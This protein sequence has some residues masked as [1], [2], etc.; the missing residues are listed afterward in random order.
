M[1]N[2]LPAGADTAP[3]LTDVLRSALESAC[4]EP[5]RLALPPVQHA[6][7][8]L[9]D[10]LGVTNL[11]AYAGHARFLAGRMQ[12]RDVIRTVTPSTTAVALSSLLTGSDPGEHGVTGYR[13]RDP[14]SGRLVNQLSEIG[15]LGDDWV[16]RPGLFE[17]ATERGVAVHVVSAPQYQDSGLTRA[18]FAG[19]A[20]HGVAL[21]AS[22]FDETAAILAGAAPTVTYLYAPELDQIGH[23]SGVASARWLAELEALD[24][25]LE[26]FAA[27][28]PV[29]VGIL[30][31]ADHGVVDIPAE[32]HVFLDD[33]PDLLDGVAQIG[34]EPRGRALYFVPE[35]TS[36]QRTALIDG[37]RQ[38]EQRRA[39][40]FTRDEAIEAGVFGVVDPALTPRLAD[41]YLFAR[42]GIAYYDRRESDRRAELMVGQHGSLTDEEV[43]VPLIRLGAFRR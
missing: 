11:R 38:A 3:R 35:L 6:V 41:L 28:L 30:L 17:R 8:V 9:V 14:E 20:F 36:G 19:A 7:V 26:R 33:A 24:A 5:N 10:G 42:A 34:G 29:N 32:R 1:A 43:R 27:R 23:K 12:K 16:R 2:M 25:E 15:M 21:R 37:W 4:G 22:R 39:W 18:I 13:V 40:V 31:T